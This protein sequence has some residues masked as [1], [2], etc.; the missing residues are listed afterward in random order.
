MGSGL[1]KNKSSMKNNRI[2]EELQK[3]QNSPFA[4]KTDKQLMAYEIL[5]E[6]YK[7]QNSGI[8]PSALRKY[9]SYTNRICKLTPEQAKEIR[10]KHIPHVYGKQKLAKEYGVSVSVVYRIITGKAWKEI[11]MNNE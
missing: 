2:V 5:H 8:Q 4:K 10:E 1:S 7:N 3:V 11:V 6:L 9:N